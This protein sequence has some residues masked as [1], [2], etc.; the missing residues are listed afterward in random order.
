MDLLLPQFII[1]MLL[2]MVLFFGIGFLFNMLLR[3]TWFMVILYPIV[4]IMIV[5]DIRFFEYFTKPGTSFQLLGSD[6]LNLSVS[7]ITIL[8][9]GLIGAILSGI[10][11]KMLRVRGYQMF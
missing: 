11:I 6:L 4:V 2:F 1:S 10:A 7:D 9:C 8:A 3:A 5:D